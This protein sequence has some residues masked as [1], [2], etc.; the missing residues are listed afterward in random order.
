MGF[1]GLLGALA[2]G[3]T[4]KSSTPSE[5]RDKEVLYDAARREPGRE[6]RDDSRCTSVQ[7]CRWS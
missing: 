4:F 7:E 5:V 3:V 2:F 1:C 6:L